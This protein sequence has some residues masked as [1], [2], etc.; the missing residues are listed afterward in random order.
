MAIPSRCRLT[1][2]ALSSSPPKAY[3]AAN[4][5]WAPDFD[6][7]IDNVANSEDATEE[8]PQ[9]DA[10]NEIANRDDLKAD[11]LSAN[12]NPANGRVVSR[13]TRSPLW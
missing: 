3:L 7:S 13:L 1:S 10:E 8:S 9:P 2:S 6:E 4:A 12:V 11:A 5:A